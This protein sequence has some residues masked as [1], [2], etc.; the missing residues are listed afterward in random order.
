MRIRMLHKPTGV[1]VDGMALNRFIPGQQYEVGNHLGALFLAEG[2]AEPVPLDIP[3]LVIPF[4][5]NDLFESKT[6]DSHHPPKLVRHSAADG[7]RRKRQ[8]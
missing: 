2:W 6:I 1:A 4:S 3:A 7:H 5:E 8:R